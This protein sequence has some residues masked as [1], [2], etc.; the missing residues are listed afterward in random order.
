MCA[1]GAGDDEADEDALDN[2]WLLV[3]WGWS[4]ASLGVWQG[5]GLPGGDSYTQKNLGVSM[6]VARRSC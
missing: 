4:S 2:E 1:G 5:E 6:G 3:S